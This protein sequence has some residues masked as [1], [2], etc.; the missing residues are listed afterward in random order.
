VIDQRQNA[1][2]RNLILLY[3]AVLDTRAK[4]EVYQEKIADAVEVPAGVAGMLADA[5]AKMQNAKSII[6]S[7][8]TQFEVDAYAELQEAN[9]LY[10]SV[11][12]QLIAQA[13]QMA[14][15]IPSNERIKRQIGTL[16]GLPQFYHEN[17]DGPAVGTW[18]LGDKI[19]NRLAQYGGPIPPDV[20]GNEPEEPTNP[21][22]GKP[23]RGTEC[24]PGRSGNAGG[25]TDC[26]LG[27]S[28]NAG[29][30]TDCCPGNSGNARG[31]TDCCPGRSGSA[32]GCRPVTSEQE[33]ALDN[34]IMR[35]EL[36]TDERDIVLLL[37]AADKLAVHKTAMEGVMV[38]PP[39]SMLTEQAEQIGDRPPV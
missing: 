33:I 13:V 15:T 17:F 1:S 5:A 3:N 29:G 6:D 12:E 16:I 34:G 35:N 2:R 31:R 25:R 39:A 10:R 22:C 18:E 14:Q 24:C 23:V 32:G 38:S 37:E 27:R 26:C 28:G 36:S 30:R 7:G 11:Q 19:L 21:A 4:T 20:E 8:Q 9:L